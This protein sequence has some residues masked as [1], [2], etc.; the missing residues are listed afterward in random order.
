MIYIY[1]IC[2]IL[3]IC[4]L[5][6]YMGDFDLKGMNNCVFMVFMFDVFFYMLF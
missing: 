3:L 2:L 5:Y 4:W 6:L 1:K